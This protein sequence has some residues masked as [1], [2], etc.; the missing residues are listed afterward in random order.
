MAAERYLE[1]APIKEAIIDIRVTSP[2]QVTIEDLGRG[3]AALKSDYPNKSELT[4]GSFGIRI[5]KGQTVSTS[6]EQSIEG[7]RYASTDGTQVVQFRSNGFTFS[8]LE[9]Y[10]TWKQMKQEAERLWPIYVENVN[11]QKIVRV[12]IRYINVMPIPL[13]FG[14]FGNVLTA[15]PQMPD[16]LS[17]GVSSFITRIVTK[18]NDIDATAIT[19]QAFDTIDNNRAPITLDIDVFADRE[20]LPE[21][22]TFW[23]CLEQLRIF[24]N[25]IFFK[26]ITEKTAELF[27]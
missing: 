23:D 14:E 17:Q 7:Y 25:E 24:K 27:E 3:F 16:G 5:D 13:P 1:R 9:P 10:Q 18:N 21:E 2:E 8:R 4:Q 22:P 26:S 11:P 6:M 20:F 12:A 15:P 19:T